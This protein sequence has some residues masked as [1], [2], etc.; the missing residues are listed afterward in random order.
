[1]GPVIAIDEPDDARVAPFATLPDIAL[2][3]AREEAE[4]FFVVEGMAV[5]RELLRS[6]Y[7]VRSLLLTP[8]RLETLGPALASVDVPIY[9]AEQDVMNRVTGF[10]IHRGAVALAARVP[11]TPAAD[12]LARTPPLVAVVEDVNDPENLGALFRNAA[13]FGL[14]AVLLSPRALDP[15][16][17]RVVRVSMGHVLHVPFARLDPWPDA[18]AGLGYTVVAMTP[19]EGAQDLDAVVGSTTG[20]VAVLVGAEGPGLSAAAL[21]LADQRCRI[22]IAAAVDSLNVATAAAIAFHAFARRRGA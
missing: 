21:A 2:R 10:N 1:V 9:V 20:P 18:L 3:R 4:G 13:A 19:A 12:V 5:I 6:R 17:R 7:P 11:A 14:G 8:S 16:Y 22:P 15:L